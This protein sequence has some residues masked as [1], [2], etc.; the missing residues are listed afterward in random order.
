MIH[1]ITLT[2]QQPLEIVD[3]YLGDHREF[4]TKGYERGLFIASGPK[5]P[6]TGGII[7]ARG[8]LNVIKE[9]IA[10][11]PFS[12]NGIASYTYNSFTAVLSDDGFKQYL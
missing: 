2:Y 4:L 7:I 11:D 6:R 1:V 5:T 3:K 12:V 10:K 9:L 8:D